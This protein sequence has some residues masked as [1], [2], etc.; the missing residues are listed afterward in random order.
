MNAAFIILLLLHGLIHL[1]GFVKGFWPARVSRLTN[2]VSKASGAFWLAATV[3]FLAAGILLALDSGS[4]WIAAL[5][6]LLIS[7][8]LIVQSWSDAKFGTIANVIILLPLVVAILGAL[9]SSFPNRFRSE[10]T[11]MLARQP[12]PSLL[13]ME[14]I[15]HL[16]VPVQKYLLYAGAV[17]KSKVVNVRA[18]FRGSMKRS[19]GS[20]WMDITSDQYDWFGD[21]ARLFYIRSSIFGI[22]FD[23]LHMYVGNSATMQI[24]VASVFQVADAKGEKMTHGETVTLFNDMCFIAPPALIDSSIAWRTIDSLNVEATF[25]NKGNTITAVLSFNENGELTNFTSN[26]RYLSADGKTYESYPWSTPVGSYREYG[27]RK[28]A[29]YGEAVWRMPAGDFTYA[30]FNLKAI[31]YNCAGFGEIR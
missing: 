24:N 18:V 27:G 13:T 3:L 17:G 6:A 1:M 26:D 31:E 8:A 28:V 12:Q 15:R 29:S 25:T 14:D 23:G 30:R 5:P 16:P 11:E 7:Q 4:W 20:D 2:P 21:P 22:P 19:V 10:A 9:P